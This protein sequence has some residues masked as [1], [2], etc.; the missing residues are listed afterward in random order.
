LTSIDQS[1]QYIEAIDIYDFDLNCACR[2]ALVEEWMSFLKA[3]EKLGVL[4]FCEGSN[5]FYF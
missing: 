1:I 5:S 4:G 3:L 2:L